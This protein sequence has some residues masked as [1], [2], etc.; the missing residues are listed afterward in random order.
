MPPHWV[1]SHGSGRFSWPQPDLIRQRGAELGKGHVTYEDTVPMV[2][3]RARLIYCTMRH[4]PPR[5]HKVPSTRTAGWYLGQCIPSI[6]RRQ[7]DVPPG[8][9]LVDQGLPQDFA[10]RVLIQGRLKDL[11]GGPEVAGGIKEPSHLQIR[12]RVVGIRFNGQE[13]RLKL[14]LGGVA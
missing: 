11:P 5:H 10:L 3:D 13:E 14:I 1:R 4:Q 7:H 12:T 6:L 8:E 2:K 9:T